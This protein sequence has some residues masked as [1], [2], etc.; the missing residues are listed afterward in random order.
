M[1]LYHGSDIIVDNPRIIKSS[2]TL[3]YGQGFYTT[4]SFA[5]AEK[6]VRH[7][8]RGKAKHG[9]VCTYDF[10]DNDL[11]NLNVLRFDTPNEDWLDFVIQNRT[12]KDF[13]HGYDIVY[14]PVANDK[15][16][17]AF[18]LYESGVFNK[19]DLIKELRAYKLVDQMLFHTEKA[20]E[21]ISYSNSQ[22]IILQ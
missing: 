3:D 14:G 7:K 6:W 20:L 21:K 19:Q 5:Q 15:V 1:I 22:I 17:A 10:D 12:D 2:R 13:D 16:Y 4:T 11:S 9:F 18:G 8:L